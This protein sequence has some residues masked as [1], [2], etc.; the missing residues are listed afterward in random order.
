MWVFQTLKLTLLEPSSLIQPVFSKQVPHYG[1][2]TPNQWCFRKPPQPCEGTK[3]SAV[4]P[5]ANS[6]WSPLKTPNGAADVHTRLILMSQLLSDM[7]PTFTRCLIKQL[8]SQILSW[9][10]G[11]PIWATE[12]YYRK[13]DWVIYFLKGLQVRDVSKFYFIFLWIETGN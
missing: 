8:F 13:K 2:V 6:H 1:S 7:G 12:V 3:W 4:I 5:K 11:G 10:P 9:Q